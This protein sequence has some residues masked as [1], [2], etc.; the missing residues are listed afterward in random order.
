LTDKPIFEREQIAR[1]VELGLGVD[2]P[3]KIE[4]ITGDTPS[5]EYGDKIKEILMNG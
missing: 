2:S 3:E 4:F 1:A 5:R